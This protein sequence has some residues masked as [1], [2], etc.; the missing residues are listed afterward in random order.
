[1][2]F[3]KRKCD[4]TLYWLATNTPIA[5]FESSSKTTDCR[6]TQEEV[7]DRMNQGEAIES[8]AS[9]VETLTMYRE[10]ITLFGVTMHSTVDV[11]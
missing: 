11:S 8:I 5:T 6:V 3:L 2:E 10:K 9:S 7:I 1:M 4:N